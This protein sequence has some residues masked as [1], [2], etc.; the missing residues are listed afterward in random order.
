MF[1]RNPQRII[2]FNLGGA[3]FD[4]DLLE[5]GEDTPEHYRLAAVR[6]REGLLRLYQPLIARLGTSFALV[7]VEE[8]HDLG[9]C[10]EVVAR[11][12]DRLPAAIAL[13]E[14][15]TENPPGTW[16][17]LEEADPVDALP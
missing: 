17:E 2:S 1:N 14:F 6:Y 16:S 10:Y 9:P 11:V 15:M 4:E 13:V 7:V 5:L 12:T 3:P 8:N